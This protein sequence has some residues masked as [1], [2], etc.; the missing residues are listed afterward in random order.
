MTGLTG[1]NPLKRV[2]NPILNQHSI[3]FNGFYSISPVIHSWA[4]LVRSRSGQQ[5]LN[6]D[7]H[8]SMATFRLCRWKWAIQGSNL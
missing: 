3:R 5:T 7:N 2:N 8:E 1:Q 4:E 6:L